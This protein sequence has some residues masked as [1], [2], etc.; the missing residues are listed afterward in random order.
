MIRRVL[1]SIVMFLIVAYL[2]L[3]VTAFS[4]KPEKQV[5]SQIELV[6]KDTVNAGFVTRNE[7]SE[8]LKKK[9]IHPVG[10]NMDGIHTKTIER[11]IGKHP[12]VDQAE[13]YKT[14]SG[15]ICVEVSQRIP[16]LRI[17]S[18]NGENY[19]V[20]N[21]GAVMPP[22]AKCTAHRAIVTGKVDQAF[23]TKDLYKLGV[24]LQNNKFWNAQIE[25][26]NVLDGRRLEL[27][28]RVGNHIIYL[29]KADKF[30]E[31]LSR[32]KTFYEKGLNK[33]GWNKYSRI[34]LE[35]DNQIICTKW[36][37]N[38]KSNN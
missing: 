10:K 30:E 11:E 14:P 27:V 23:A 35:F 22:T 9:N 18:S 7:V 33:V 6:I 13:C 26:I 2:G 36:D 34:S 16:V 25:Q 5:C 3:A 38:I 17:M 28:P 31:K 21:K 20:D 4:R 15:K 32:L 29:G 1:L 12:L 37:D 8:L 24:Y 19:Y